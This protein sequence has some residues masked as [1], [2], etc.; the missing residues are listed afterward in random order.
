MKLSNDVL[1]KGY[2]D[3]IW[4]KLKDK[5]CWFGSE[6]LTIIYITQD[7]FDYGM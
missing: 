6:N 2:D 5:D 1:E 3:L 7:H 4:A